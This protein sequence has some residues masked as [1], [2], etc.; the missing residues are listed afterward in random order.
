MIGTPRS[1][2]GGGADGPARAAVL[3]EARAWIGTP[4]R[5]QAAVKGVGCD[6]AGLVRGVGEAAGV[7]TIA[8]EDWR[9]VAN[10]GRQP[11][12][13]RMNA[14]LRRFLVRVPP[15]KARPGDV[16]WMHWRE[17]L[18][19]HLAILGHD[20]QGGRRLTIIHAFSDFERVIE[21]GFTQEWRERVTSCWRYPSLAIKNK[22]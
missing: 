14:A 19:M 21:H 11:H 6:C 15:S 20:E 3:A 16:L 1:F 13:K 2:P 4:F 8:P 18:P 9:Q 7:L 17:G 12:P 22:A 10:Y 5:H